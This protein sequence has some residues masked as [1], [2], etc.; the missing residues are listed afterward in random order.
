[1][2][3]LDVNSLVALAWPNHQFHGKTV[4]RL[5]KRPAPRWATCAITQ[6]GF[7]RL[8]CNEAAVGV[9]K[10]PAEAHALLDSLT[11]DRAHVFLQ[12]LP[13]P[14][15]LDRAFDRALGHQQVTDAYLV[16]LA[17]HHR[18]TLLTFDQRAGALSPDAAVVEVLR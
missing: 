18:A 1:V 10:T 16:A 9:R 17:A 3:L 2:L 4:Q 5:E 7:L 8:S 14:A 15:R 13:A 6:L 12:S 11:R